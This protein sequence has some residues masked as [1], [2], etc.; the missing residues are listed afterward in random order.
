MNIPNALT[1]LRFLM[2]PLFGYFVF[3][4]QYL[5]AVII[6]SIAALTDMLDGFFARKYNMITSWGKVADP[7]AD[8]LMQLTAVII[9]NTQGKIPTILAVAAM[10]KDVVIGIG[11]YLLYRQNNLIAQANWYGKLTTVILYFTI[12]TVLFSLPFSDIFVII[13]LLSV[14]FSLLMYALKFIR[15]KRS[16]IS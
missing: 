7:V 16:K 8:K 14:L 15:I 4:K 1:I 12:V 11:S 13:S 9:L 6:Y 3:N 5:I 10:L 2:I